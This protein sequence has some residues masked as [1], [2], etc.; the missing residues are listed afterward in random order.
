MNRSTPVSLISV[1]NLPPP[2]S[3]EQ[4]SVATALAFPRQEAD[5][6]AAQWARIFCQGNHVRRLKAAPLFGLEKQPRPLVRLQ[7]E[8]ADDFKAPETHTARTHSIRLTTA[9]TRDPGSCDASSLSPQGAVRKQPPLGSSLPPT[10]PA[11]P[12]PSHSGAAALIKTCFL[13]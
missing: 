5:A 4:T 9:R 3:H 13:F 10:F 7:R 6:M 8:L 12:T 1:S 2:S 11:T